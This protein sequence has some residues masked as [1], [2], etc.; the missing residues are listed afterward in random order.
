[1]ISIKKLLALTLALA[2]VLTLAAC[3]GKDK[4]EAGSGSSDGSSESA[5]DSYV[6]SGFF[7]GAIVAPTLGDAFSGAVA[8]SGASSFVSPTTE[9][10]GDM[11]FYGDMELYDCSGSY[12]DGSYDVWGYIRTD[13]DGKTFLELYDTK[14]YTSSDA[15]FLSMWIDLYSDHIEADIGNE[16]AWILERYLTA[17]DAGYFSPYLDNG[18][19]KFDYPYKNGGDSCEIFI[20]LREDGTPWDEENDVLPPSYEE[21][22]ASLG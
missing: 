8:G 19:L 20:T 6:S 7:D 10:S 13:S 1:M 5:G 16:N 11:H 9:L 12:A 2:V 21:Y 3:G 4:E 17:D 22:K 14:D 15:P 18:A